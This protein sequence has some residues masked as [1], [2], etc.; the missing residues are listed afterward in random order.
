MISKY[1]LPYFRTTNNNTEISRFLKKKFLARIKNIFPYHYLIQANHSKILKGIKLLSDKYPYFLRLDIS[2][3]YPSI[4]HR[5]L[6]EKLPEIYKKISDKPIS[7]RL[8]KYFKD[9]I[10]VFLQKSP[11]QKGLPIGSSLSHILA[12]IFLLFLD[13]RIKNPFLRFN[14]DYLIFCK[15]AKEPELILKNTI[16]PTLNELDLELNYKK[17]N[18]GRFHKD[19]VNFIGFEFFSGH[20][21]IQKEKLEE[22][23]RKITEITRLNRNKSKEAII[24]SFNNKIKGFGHYYKLASCKTDFKD[25][26][27]FIRMRLRRYLLKQRNLLPKQGNLVLTNE[28]LKQIG[29]KSLE[30]IKSRIKE[31][32]P[33][34]PKKRTN[35][36]FP[37]KSIEDASIKYKIDYIIKQ[38]QFLSTTIK[39]IEERLKKTEKSLQE[40][41]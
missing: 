33:L 29:L 38:I 10:P 23:K 20:L 17:L 3:Y 14:D 34:K 8:Y 30:R 11:Y 21:L 2:M 15:T 18:S 25:L 35:S 19:K 40:K 12:G 32:R 5:I 39:R 9:D 24:K 22:F 7:K 31:K 16:V 37:W 27:S 6:I 41:K 4:N 1:N 28:Y 26:D 13:L 36:S